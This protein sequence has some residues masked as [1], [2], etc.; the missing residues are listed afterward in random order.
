MKSTIKMRFEN[1]HVFVE[2]D[3][4]WFSG[5]EKDFQLYLPFEKWV[6]DG[7]PTVYDVELV[8]GRE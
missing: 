3:Q 1:D 6:E 5:G 4:A 7:R 8:P 2:G